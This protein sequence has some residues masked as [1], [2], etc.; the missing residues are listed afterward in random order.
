MVFLVELRGFVDRDDPLPR[1]T[2]S[3]SMRNYIIRRGESFFAVEAVHR[4]VTVLSLYDLF[5]FY[6]LYQGIDLCFCVV[7]FRIRIK[8]IKLHKVVFVFFDTGVQ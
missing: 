1:L 8:K 6:T 2:V 3:L 7:F 4:A 5:I